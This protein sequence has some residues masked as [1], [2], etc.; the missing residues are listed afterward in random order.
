ETV[1]Q[2][3]VDAYL[4]EA[5]PPEQWDWNAFMQALRQVIPTDA[6]PEIEDMK[7]KSRDEIKQSIYERAVEF[8][9]QKEQFFG[10]ETMRDYERRVMLWAINT[11]WIDH[12]ANMDYLRDHIHLRAYGQRDP[13]IEYQ[14][15]AYEMFQQLLQ[16]IRE[17]VVRWAFYGEPEQQ[18]QQARV[19]QLHERHDE[20]GISDAQR[21]ESEAAIASAEERTQ[22]KKP[23]RVKKI[24]RNDP[25]PCGSG[26]KYKKCCML[27]DQ[28]RSME[29][30]S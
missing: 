27:K 30:V 25:C 6:M 9:E 26:K 17:E 13:F 2:S 20:A 3:Y 15:E 7:G 11:K 1:I 5:V 22:V 8:Y 14:C 21:A 18:Q 4:S 24:G 19:S 12:L 10:E 23:V 16:S 29:V 28:Q